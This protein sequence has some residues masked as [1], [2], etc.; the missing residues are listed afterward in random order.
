MSWLTGPKKLLLQ[1]FH[2]NENCTKFSIWA[3]C[4]RPEVLNTHQKGSIGGSYC[5]MWF[6]KGRFQFAHG[7][8]GWGS[9]P[10]VSVY[11]GS[12]S[13]GK[14]KDTQHKLTSTHSN[15]NFRRHTGLFISNVREWKGQIGNAVKP[16]WHFVSEAVSQQALL[17]CPMGQGVWP[18]GKLVL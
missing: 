12:H 15:R 6:D 8:H 5:A 10:I 1:L 3:L 14:T 11:W 16:T 4:H 18:Q 2:Q 7:F 17:C 9:N 13:C